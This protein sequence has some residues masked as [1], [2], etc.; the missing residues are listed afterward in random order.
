MNP[1]LHLNFEQPILADTFVFPTD[2][3]NCKQGSWKFYQKI[4]VKDTIHLAT[5]TM[6]S[7][8][9]LLH[10]PDCLLFY[11]SP[12]A[13]LN[14]HTD[15]GGADAWAINWTLTPTRAEMIWYT[16][17]SPGKSEIAYD[18]RTDKK[19]C[20]ETYSIDDENV[21]SKIKNKITT[22]TSYQEHEVT[23]VCRQEIGFPTLIRTGIPHGGV[24][25]SDQGSWMLSLRFMTHM[26]WEQATA[27]FQPF[28]R[29]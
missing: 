18:W 10:R 29:D 15:Q 4:P 26:S 20:R 13:N 21:W 22:L 8:I 7:N 11:A 2:T 23:E 14:I 27:M 24:N 28:I 17:D 5:L 25:H 6:L 9:D 1:F 19:D 16:T 12:G 3:A